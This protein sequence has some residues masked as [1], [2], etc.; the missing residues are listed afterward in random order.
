M[1]SAYSH[2]SCFSVKHGSYSGDIFPCSIYLLSLLV[3]FQVLGTRFSTT[4]YKIRCPYCKLF[5]PD[6][7]K[8][9]T[10]NAVKYANI[11]ILL[12]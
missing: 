5:M 11:G 2:F 6:N 3:D 10:L 8:I 4:Q 1:C 9:A 12:N 7:K